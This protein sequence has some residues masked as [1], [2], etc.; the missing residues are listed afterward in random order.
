MIPA[1]QNHVLMC[2]KYLYLYHQ[3]LLPIADRRVDGTLNDCLEELCGRSQPEDRTALDDAKYVSMVSNAALNL[4]GGYDSYE[5]YLAQH[6]TELIFG[7]VL[8][9]RALKSERARSI[10][11]ANNALTNG[12][13]LEGTV[14][15]WC[16]EFGF[17][18][19]TGEAKCLGTIF[20]HLSRISPSQ[21]RIR[22]GQTVLSF[23]LQINQRFKTRSNG[24]DPTRYRASQASI[25]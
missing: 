23:Q 11:F 22:Q 6:A 18:Q 13:Y 15:K 21:S 7:H 20:V 8:L 2:D 12:I 25:V 16:G 9:T 4:L 5:N 17:I 3:F 14:I 1:L 19:P 10:E 24:K